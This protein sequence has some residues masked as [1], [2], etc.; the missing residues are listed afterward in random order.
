[1]V[2]VTEWS[3][4]R[5]SSPPAK[6]LRICQRADRVIVTARLSPS[7]WPP[8]QMRLPAFA[9]PHHVVVI[10]RAAL[11]KGGELKF[12]LVDRLGLSLASVRHTVTVEP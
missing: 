1:M 11:K 4:L 2:A 7:P 12:A 3:S 8:F 10:D 5:P 9:Y 6:I